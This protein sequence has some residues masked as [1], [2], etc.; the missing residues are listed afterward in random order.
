MLACE[1]H[2]EYN[3]IWNGIEVSKI[4]RHCC[5]LCG[6]VCSIDIFHKDGTMITQDISEYHTT[7][8]E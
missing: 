5:E 1:D 3:S 4:V 8:S 2:V 6:E 7:C